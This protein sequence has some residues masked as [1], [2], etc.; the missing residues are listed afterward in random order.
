MNPLDLVSSFRRGQY[1]NT[2][3]IA[4]QKFDEFKYTVYQRKNVP[5]GA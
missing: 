2:R 4:Y 5:V 3:W 1:R